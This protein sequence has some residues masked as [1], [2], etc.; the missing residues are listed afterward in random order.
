MI[1]ALL[2]AVLASA[3]RSRGLVYLSTVLGA[4]A[5]TQWL[6]SFTGPIQEQ[7]VAYACLALGYGVAGYAITLLKT[8]WA[9]DEAIENQSASIGFPSSS[10]KLAWLLLWETPLQISGL[11]V[12]FGA[13]LLTFILGFDLA[14]WMARALFGLPFRDIVDLATVQMVV[15]VLSILGLLYLVTSLIYRRLRVGYL[16]IGMLVSSW[17]VYAF[18][19]QLWD[20]LAQLQWYAVPTGLYLLGVA[21]LEW[22]YGNR[23]LARWLDYA[24]TLLMLGSLFWQT[25]IF[26]WGFALM[27]GLEGLIAIWWGSA[28]R[29]RRFFYAGIVGVILATLGQLLN[30][31]RHINQW[32]T[33]GVIGLLLVLVGVIVERK[34]ESL[35]AWQDAL[36][37]WE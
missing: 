35:K 14:G 31:L 37:D 3:W 12:S 28:R 4:V 5:L 25:L 19:V 10:G 20:N 17:L 8:R 9:K 18:Y 29:L 26:G 13:L 32:I 16:A 22:N 27:M 7:P 33:F 24:A 36:E 23:P 15:R 2:V 34:R 11:I 21:Y 1:N 30:A 6:G